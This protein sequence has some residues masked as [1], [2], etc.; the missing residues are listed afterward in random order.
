MDDEL[1]E[2]RFAHTT[3]TYI[4]DVRDLDNPFISG[5]YSSSVNDTD[6]N[7]YTKG[8][9]VYESN[10]RS[11][12]R[13]LD[14]SLVAS[15]IL[16][17]VAFF[18]T[19]PKIDKNGFRGNWSNYPYFDSGVVVLSDMQRGLFIVRPNLTPATPDFTMD[20]IPAIQYACQGSDAV[21]AVN[22]GSVHGFSDAVTLSA[23]SAPPGAAVSF[24]PNP[25]SP[26]GSSTMTV[27]T[28]GLSG[29]VGITV[30]GTGSSGSHDDLVTLDISLGTVGPPSLVT[31]EDGATAQSTR[32]TFSWNPVADSLSYD[33]E[34]ASDP[35]FA[36]VV[37]A[38]NLSETS[39]APSAALSHDRTYY[40]RVRANNACGAGL[41]SLVFDFTTAPPSSD[42][43][44][45]SSSSGGNVG[46]GFADEDIIAFDR[47]AGTWALHFDGSDVGLAA[48][49]VNALHI[50][51]DASLL[52]SITSSDFNLAGFRVVDDS[53]VL[54]F[55]PTSLGE[56]TTGSFEMYFDGSDVGLT[57]SG[58]DVDALYVAPDGALYLSVAGRPTVSGLPRQ[59][60]EDILKFTP[61]SLGATTS[62][63]WAVHFDGSDIALDEK[64]EDVWG[65]WLSPNGDIHATTR[66]VFAVAGASGDG[67]DIFVCVPGSIG[68]TTTCVS[69]LYWAGT[70]G[71]FGTEVIDA[72]HIKP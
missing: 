12:V 63:T 72:V 30:T 33:I 25:V 36:T 17:E 15:G 34:I 26:G 42:V 23:M 19:D 50:L 54:R 68:E 16:T 61:T 52:L 71:G 66:G 4:W 8:D 47:G 67:S 39:Y 35:G 29:T 6:H 65:V 27:S 10:Y 51:D 38:A 5:I 9:Y 7:L 20:V 57:G 46:F 40:W 43:I 48:T 2:K 45:M 1:D 41:D 14:T 18:D 22:V 37:D 13:V 44:F 24:S 21:F 60:D 58:E 32:S 53:D 56:T 70:D 11:G 3:R 28:A 55:V 49:D 59:Q 69:T 64:T 31:P 62:G